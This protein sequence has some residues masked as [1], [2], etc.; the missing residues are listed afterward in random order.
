MIVY[1][2]TTEDAY[3]EIIRAKEFVP[4]FFSTALDAVYGKG[5]YF[6]DLR[7][8]TSDEELYQI[9]G[10]PEPERVERYLVFDIDSTLLQSTRLH[11]YRLALECM[12]ENIIKLMNYYI[13]NK[14]VIKFIKGG[15]RK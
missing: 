6:T 10:Q 14:V 3:D 5:W 4:S 15:S 12:Q 8:S 13:E 11:V 2:Y 9:W 1:H 7:P